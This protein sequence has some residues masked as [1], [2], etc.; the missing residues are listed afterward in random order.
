MYFTH[1]LGKP[2]FYCPVGSK[3]VFK[4]N[5][6]DWLYSIDYYIVSIPP[7]LLHPGV[8]WPR[9][10]MTKGLDDW[11]F[12]KHPSEIS[13]IL[14]LVKSISSKIFWVHILVT[15]LMLLVSFD[16]PYQHQKH[17]FCKRPVR[18]TLAWHEFMT[19]LQYWSCNLWIVILP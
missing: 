7:F 11:N 5:F 1:S 12:W 15:Q 8:G 4:G 19:T 13:M 14:I 3:W 2:R 16:T 17:R 9:G 6:F 18:R 10:W